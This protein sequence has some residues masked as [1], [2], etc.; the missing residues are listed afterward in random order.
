[1]R[2]NSGKY[3]PADAQRIFARFVE[4]GYTIEEAVEATFALTGL[5]PE[6]KHDA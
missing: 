2:Y 4:R 6:V 1:M 3:S 5:K